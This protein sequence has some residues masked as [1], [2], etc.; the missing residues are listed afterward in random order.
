MH[1]MGM[2]CGKNRS[3]AHN[4]I[5]VIEL[6]H[7]NR[8]RLQ[9]CVWVAEDDDVIQDDR[10]VPSGTDCLFHDACSLTVSTQRHMSI[11]ICKVCVCVCVCVCVRVC[12]CARVCV[13]ACERAGGADRTVIH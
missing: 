8:R 1:T 3:P 5:S 9:D 12:V 2:R 11:G 10:L 6:H 13:R 7:A 4:L